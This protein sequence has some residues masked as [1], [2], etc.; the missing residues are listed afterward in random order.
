[1]ETGLEKEQIQKTDE[2]PVYRYIIALPWYILKFLN[3]VIPNAVIAYEIE[4]CCNSGPT[5]QKSAG[6]KLWL[7]AGTYRPSS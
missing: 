2:P 1:M 3:I 4:N 5:V 6:S 7:D